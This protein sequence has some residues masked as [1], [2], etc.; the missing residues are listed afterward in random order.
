[1]KLSVSSFPAF[2]SFGI[3]SGVNKPPKSYTP[4]VFTKI[5]HAF[6]FTGMNYDCCIFEI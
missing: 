6:Q 5:K 3:L 1:M 2:T 4:K